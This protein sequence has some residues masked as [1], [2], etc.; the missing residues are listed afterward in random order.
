MKLCAEAYHPHSCIP[1]LDSQCVSLF[2]PQSLWLL[3]LFGE[4]GGQEHAY[5]SLL[6]KMEGNFI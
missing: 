4:N 1:I 5:N 6:H 3:L 2:F